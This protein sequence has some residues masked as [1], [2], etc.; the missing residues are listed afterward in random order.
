MATPTIPRYTK[1]AGVSGGLLVALQRSLVTC[2]CTRVHTYIYSRPYIHT[3]LYRT[4]VYICTSV[5]LVECSSS[6]S[7]VPRCSIRDEL[8]AAN[9]PLSL[10]ES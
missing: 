8:A 9:K 5:C 1:W 4:L 7:C 2:T 10:S 3:C 6:A